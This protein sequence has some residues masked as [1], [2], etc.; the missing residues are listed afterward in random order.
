MS[1]WVSAALSVVGHI[2]GAGVVAEVV[3]AVGAGP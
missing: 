1:A 3:V 2:E